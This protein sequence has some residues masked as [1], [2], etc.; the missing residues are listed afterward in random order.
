MNR[1]SKSLIY[2]PFR[3]IQLG[4]T[5]V[6]EVEDLEREE[7]ELTTFNKELFLKYFENSRGVIAI[8]CEKVQISRATYYNW[9]NNDP[10]FKSAV[11]TILKSRPDVLFDRM[12]N[13]A[14]NG[15]VSA[16]KFML[17]HLHDDFK[18]KVSDKKEVEV[19]MYHYPGK[20]PQTFKEPMLE[21]F[22]DYPE[23][24]EWWYITNGTPEEKEQ[25]KRR[26]EESGKPPLHDS[27]YEGPTYDIN[28]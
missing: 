24:S 23:I 20:K 7:R 12:F 28:N 1:R 15:N 9:M 22:L 19:K 25:W 3:P 8:T 6:V 26:R 18:K 21:D 4:C 5:Y 2:N 11:N 16:L 17:T 10:E 27:T 14:V 13:E